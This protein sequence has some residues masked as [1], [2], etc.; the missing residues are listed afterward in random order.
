MDPKT[1]FPYLDEEQLKPYDQM[2]PFGMFWR[3]LP[4]GDPTVE[5]LMSR[6]L[7]AYISPR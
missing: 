2:V 7:D 3:W 5:I 4:L 1:V 6:D